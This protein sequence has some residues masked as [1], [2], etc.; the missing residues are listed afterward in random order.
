LLPLSSSAAADSTESGLKL[1]MLIAVLVV[2]LVVLQYLLW[3]SEDG[4]RQTHT[5]RIAIQAQTEENVAL[6]ERNRALEADVIDLKSGLMAIEERARSEMGMVR[7][8]ETFYR[9]L[10]RSLP[11]PTEVVPAKPVAAPPRKPPAPAKLPVATAKPPIAAKPPIPAVSPS[12]HVVKPP[13]NPAQP[14]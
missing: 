8:D 12:P 1:Q 5:L 14:R 10:D 3:L 6:N 2:V 11:K 9:I 7:P 4:V 13:T